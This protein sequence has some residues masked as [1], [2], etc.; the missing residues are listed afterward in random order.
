MLITE[1]NNKLQS[2]STIL[3]RIPGSSFTNGGFL[4][5]GPDGKLYVGAGTVSE[6]SHLPQDPTSLAGKIL[7]INDDGTIPGDN[8]FEDS[9]VY[10]LG[11]RH[12]QGMAWDDDGNL[13]VA[14]HGPEKNDE[15]NVIIPGGNYG[16]PNREC[17]GGEFR[18]ALL[19]YD[20]SIEPGGILHYKSDAIGLEHP[21]VMAS[22]R[23]A[24]LYQV[25]FEE[26]L[27]SPKVDPQRHGQDKGR[28][29]V[30]RR[31]HLRNHVEH[32]RKRF[33]GRNR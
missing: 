31:Q 2:V 12:P 24:N 5:F 4:K 27:P 16:W 17:S 25:D 23:A 29:G 20:P 8:P 26:G 7:R 21:F 13:Y 6:A 15:I 3:D 10:S 1:S 9:P 19:C 14:E 32:G 11:H 18:G 30:R 33:S 28:G 22:M